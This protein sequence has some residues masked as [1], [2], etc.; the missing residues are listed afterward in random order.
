MST[1]FVLITG[2]TGFIGA[3][4]LHQALA[5]GYRTR[6]T[7]RK[8]E[9][10]AAIKERHPD[11]GD[12]LET[13]V[14]PVLDNVEA[15]TKALSGGV[16]YVLHIA[17]PMPQP[18][19][20]LQTGYIDPAVHS[21]IAVLD[22]AKAVPSVKRVI[23]TS[24][25]LALAPLDYSTQ[26]GFVIREGS[27]RSIEVDPSVPVPDGPAAEGTKYHISKILAHR[28]TLDWV[29]AAKAKSEKIPEIVTV[30]PFFVIGHDR[31]HPAKGGPAHGVN[32]IY[33]A[34]L[35]SPFPYVPS[36]L[37]DVRDVA[38]IH[39][40]AVAASSQL[41]EGQ[42]REI[43]EVIAKGPRV[44][45]EEIVAFVKEKYPSF[46][47]NQTTSRPFSDPTTSDTTRAQRDFGVPQFHAAFDS[48]AALL[49]Q[50]TE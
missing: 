1:P 21:T 20:D 14:V 25:G 9:Q 38:A 45:W 22:A 36:A 18:G 28:A 23:I 15:L 8:E 47:V 31:T 5:K 10:A 43:T 11:A 40:A 19:L 50:N 30:H 7:V 46:T 42:G 6:V 4:V 49:D 24:S 39:V 3:E 48:V 26:P 17:S 37:V 2:A 34:S 12:R 41:L 44:T 33:L 16:D 13:V 29:D 35:Q 27:N 32:Q